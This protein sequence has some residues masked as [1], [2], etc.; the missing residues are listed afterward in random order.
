LD[1]AGE[2]FRLRVSLQ[3]LSCFGSRRDPLVAEQ[4]L[5]D[6]R[7]DQIGDGMDEGAACPA[8]IGPCLL[9]RPY[10]AIDDCCSCPAHCSSCVHTR[11]AVNASGAH[12]LGARV[13]QASP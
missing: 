4:D 2:R 10:G 1:V 5:I 3:Q 9:A 13:G 7:I 8:G 11:E 6:R 12:L